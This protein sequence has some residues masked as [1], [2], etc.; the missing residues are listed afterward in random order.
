M[1]RV[2]YT[3]RARADLIDIVESIAV[4]NPP[5]ADA[6]AIELEH[7]CSLLATAPE[8]GRRRPEVG[9]AIRSLVHGDYLIFYRYSR[10]RDRI[11]ILS[12]CTAG[13]GFLA[14]AADVQ[15]SIDGTAR[16]S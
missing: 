12:V 11:S 3:S 15:T 1:T 2:V 7:H 4:D 10:A 5:A 13:E 8:M 6:F 16:H 14:W 9:P